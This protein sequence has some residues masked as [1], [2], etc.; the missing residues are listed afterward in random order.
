MAS[1][2]MPKA[3]V[4]QD[5][6]LQKRP[7]SLLVSYPAEKE[8]AIE[9]DFEAADVLQYLQVAFQSQFRRRTHR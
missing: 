5:S 3:A 1:Q 2:E 4:F 6:S 7:D 9:A 8:R